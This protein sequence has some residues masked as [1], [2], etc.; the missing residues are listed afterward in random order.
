MD[1]HTITEKERTSMKKQ[2]GTNIFRLFHT[3]IHK[4]IKE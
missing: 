2:I 4:T 3:V 1:Y